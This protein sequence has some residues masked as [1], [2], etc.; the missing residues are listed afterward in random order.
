MR[1]PVL[2]KASTRTHLSAGKEQLDRGTRKYVI[3]D[4]QHPNAIQA[5]EYST[6]ADEEYVFASL[7]LYRTDI[8][9]LLENF[10]N[11]S[12]KFCFWDLHCQVLYYN[13]YSA[14]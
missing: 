14:N 13:F 9:I 8:H 4:T 11:F 5:Q 7:K 2:W 6:T 10:D 1:W 12:I 3:E